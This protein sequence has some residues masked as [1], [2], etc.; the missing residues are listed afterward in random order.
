[1][2]M[3]TRAQRM[4]DACGT[5]GTNFTREEL[6]RIDRYLDAHEPT[7]PDPSVKRGPRA[8]PWPTAEQVALMSAKQKVMLRKRYKQHGR[9]LPPYLIPMTP[10]Q[11]A[12]IGNDVLRAMKAE[13]AA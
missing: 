1:M 10:S 7:R 11:A 5:R 3:S 6:A 2:R 9:P 4:H 8:W 12:Q 13:A